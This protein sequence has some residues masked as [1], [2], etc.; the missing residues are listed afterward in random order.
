[1]AGSSG[2]EASGLGSSGV[3]VEST[4]GRSVFALITLS[5]MLILQVVGRKNVIGRYKQQ[6]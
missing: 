5:W 2:A 3:G 4:S 1:M 6:C